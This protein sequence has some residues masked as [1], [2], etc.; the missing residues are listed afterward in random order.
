MPYRVIVTRLSRWKFFVRQNT[1]RKSKDA[2]AERRDY[3]FVA[4]L[5]SRTKAGAGRSLRIERGYDVSSQPGRRAL[6]MKR[7]K[8]HNRKLAVLLAKDPV[9]FK[10][11]A[12]Y[13]MATIWIVLH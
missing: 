9:L 11:C 4:C 13:L 12:M 8:L 7:P 10:R 3:T 5:K 2:I 1:N 6:W